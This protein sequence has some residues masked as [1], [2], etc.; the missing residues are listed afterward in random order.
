MGVVYGR[1]ICARTAG[2]SIARLAACQCQGRAVQSLGS[3]GCLP[4]PRLLQAFATY[5]L[6]AWLTTN[7][8]FAQVVSIVSNLSWEVSRGPLHPAAALWDSCGDLWA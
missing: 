5:L 7:I 2:A 4:C 3:D 6:I 8:I 1:E